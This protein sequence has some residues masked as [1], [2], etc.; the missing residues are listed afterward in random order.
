MAL[1]HSEMTFPLFISFGY[2]INQFSEAF[3]IPG[4]EC[5]RGGGGGGE[6]NLLRHLP[7]CPPPFVL[8]LQDFRREDTSSRVVDL[9]AHF[10]KGY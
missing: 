3:V 8:L 9:S 6:E 2:F 5:G 4:K 7:V 10:Y 1:V